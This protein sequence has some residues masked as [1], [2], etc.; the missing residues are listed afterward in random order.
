M[1]WLPRPGK[2]KEQEGKVSFPGDSIFVVSRSHKKVY[3]SMLAEMR[4]CNMVGSLPE[5]E[6]RQ[7]IRKNV[8]KDI[9]KLCCKTML[10]LREG[11]LYF[12]K[13][14]KNLLK[15]LLRLERKILIKEI[16]FFFF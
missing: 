9:R 3:V 7:N 2:T 8:S 4:S 1:S 6:A 13:I 16:F 11:Q 14:K 10:Q 5:Y 15:L 12:K